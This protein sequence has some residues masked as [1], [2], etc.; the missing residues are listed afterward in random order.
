MDNFIYSVPNY[1]F[2]WSKYIDNHSTHDNIHHP[3]KDLFTFLNIPDT[4]LSNHPSDNNTSHTNNNNNNKSI[5][6][7]TRHK[8]SY[9]S[10][11]SKTIRSKSLY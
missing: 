11:L 9:S 5:K 7:K 1:I 2:D 3:Q 8:H 10:K 4:F 6:N